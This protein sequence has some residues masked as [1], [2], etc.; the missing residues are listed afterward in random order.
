VGLFVDA[1]NTPGFIGQC[2]LVP[3]G[4]PGGIASCVDIA[5]A[6]IPPGAHT[7][8]ALYFGDA[9]YSASVGSDDAGNPVAGAPKPSDTKVLCAPAGGGTL[10]C[11]SMV[12]DDDIDVSPSP[13]GS[14]GFFRDAINSPGFVGQCT[15]GSVGS[16]IS[17][18]RATT[19]A[20]PGGASTLWALYFGDALYQASVDADPV[21]V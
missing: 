21:T 17:S 2:A 5:T 3:M 4:G 20:V 6:G 7:V 12:A 10:D 9:T 1:I 8:W 15:L 14:V 13:G 19:S 18:C 11:A 16:G